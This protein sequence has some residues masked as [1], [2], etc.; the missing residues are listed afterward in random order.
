MAAKNLTTKDSVGTWLK[1]PVGGP[2]IREALAEAGVDAKVLAPVSF[3][4]LERVVG[5]AGDRIPPGLIDELV[6]RSNAG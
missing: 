4:S 1:H 5:M 2:L 3:F 6:T